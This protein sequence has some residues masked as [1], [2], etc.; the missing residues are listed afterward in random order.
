VSPTRERLLDTIRSRPGINKSGLCTALGL[1][2]G[3]VDYHLRVLVREGRVALRPEGR[4]TRCFPGGLETGRRVVLAALAD[5]SGSRIAFVLRHS[6]GQGVGELSQ[7]LGLSSKV[8]RRRLLRMVED[9]MLERVGK[10][11]PRYSLGSQ[12]HHLLEE[13]MVDL[14]EAP[15]H[16]LAPPPRVP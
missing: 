3:T 12:V 11:R 4:E 2:W 9:G 1:A 6:P 7:Q 16:L 15:P 8:V 13:M 14:R 10:H 5:G